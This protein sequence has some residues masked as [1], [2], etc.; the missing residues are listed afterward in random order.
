MGGASSEI[1]D[2]TT[3]GAARG[4]VVRAAWRSP[5]RPSA[6]GCAPR[7]RPASSAASIRRHRA[8]RRPLRRTARPGTS[9]GPIVDVARAPRRRSRA[10][11][12]IAVRTARVNGLLGTP[13]HR[14][15]RTALPRAHRLRQSTGGKRRARGHAAELPARRRDRRGR[16]RGSRRATTATPTSRDAAAA[17]RTSAGSPRHQRAR[18]PSATCSWAAAVTRR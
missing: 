6:S 7:R 2:A 3:D 10:A 9:A 12:P 8:G 13:T 1:D 14:R 16:H 5:A 15:R 4:R 17:A 11:P 18:R